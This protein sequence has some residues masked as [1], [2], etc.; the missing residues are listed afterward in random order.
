[1]YFSR[2]GN[3][4]FNGVRRNKLITPNSSTDIYRPIVLYLLLNESFT[5][6]GKKFQR[7]RRS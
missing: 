4:Y 2:R 1:M 6:I 7:R 5:I 3:S